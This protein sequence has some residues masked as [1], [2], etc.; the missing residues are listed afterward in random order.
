MNKEILFR[1][2][3][4]DD[5]TE[6]AGR[7]VYGD[8]L[9]ISGK[10]YIHPQANTTEVKGHLA[11]LLAVHEITPDT[12]GQYTGLEDKNGAKIFE[13]DIV[14]YNDIADFDIHATVKFGEYDQ[15]GSGGEYEPSKC[16]GVYFEMINFT[17]PGW[18][19]ELGLDPRDYNGTTTP[20]GCNVIGIEVIGNIYDNPE[21]LEAQP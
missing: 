19:E 11:K 3:G 9:K 4:V 2:R 6:M 16:I 5:G 20:L 12:L 8:R 21:L 1:G 10:I 14:R 7:W 18:A 13:G 17:R 15:D